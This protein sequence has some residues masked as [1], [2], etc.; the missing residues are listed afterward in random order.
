MHRHQPKATRI[1]K[2]QV[3]MK[4]SKETNKPVTDPKEIEVHELLNK[5]KIIIL[6]KLSGLQGDRDR[7]LN[8]S[9]KQ[10]MN[11]IRN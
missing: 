3:N 9:G 1:M 10:Y 11:K 7:Q 6:K 8:K 2:N 5:S 4:P